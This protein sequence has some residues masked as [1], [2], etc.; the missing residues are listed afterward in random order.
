M[1]LLRDT[2]SPNDIRSHIMQWDEAEATTVSNRQRRHAPRNRARRRGAT[3]V[4]VIVPTYNRPEQL[5]ATLKSIWPRPIRRGNRRGE[6]LRTD[7]ERTI[8]S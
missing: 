8:S 1:Q 4:S 7:V 2:I 5:V 6:R 3:L